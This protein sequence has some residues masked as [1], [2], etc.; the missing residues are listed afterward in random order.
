M[1]G[2]S[3]DD[4]GGWTAFTYVQT[5]GDRV[6]YGQMNVDPTQGNGGT[7]ASFQRR[8]IRNVT[9][10]AAW[11]STTA[12]D[13]GAW[14]RWRVPY[15][16]LRLERNTLAD[17]DD[18]MGTMAMGEREVYY[19]STVETKT[20]VA[21]FVTNAGV[22][23]HDTLFRGSGEH[24]LDGYEASH[25]EY[26]VAGHP[27][28][29]RTRAA[30][31]EPDSNQLRRLERIELWTKGADGKLGELVQTTHFEYDYSLCP[32]LPNSSF[33][34]QNPRVGKLTLKRVYFEYNGVRESAIRPYVFGYQY[35]TVDAGDYNALSGD[36]LAKY[37]S[38][39]R[40]V[41]AVDAAAQNPAYA[42]HMIDR[43]GNY[44][45]DGPARWAD[46]NP[47]VDQT[48]SPGFDPAA[49]QLKWIRLPSG[50]EIQVQYEQND[51]AFV[52]DHVAMAMVPLCAAD[53]V[54]NR[55]YLNLDQL[56][57]ANPPQT[58]LAA[59][60][61]AMRALYVGGGEKAYFKFLT[62][63]TG[64]AAQFSAIDGGTMEY[65]TGY[66]A[67][68]DVRIAPGNDPFCPGKVY[69]QFAAGE[70]TTPL[71]VAANF[72]QTQRNGIAGRTGLRQEDDP[73]AAVRGLMAHTGDQLFNPADFANGNAAV[74]N[75]TVV[76][77]AHSW[78][79]IPLG[80]VE[81]PVLGK[82][83]GGADVNHLVAR[84]K[85]V[86]AKKGGGVRVKRLLTFDPGLQDRTG[87]VYGTEYLYQT[88]EGYTSGVAAN[89]PAAGGE[90]SALVRLLDKRTDQSW[91]ERIIAGEDKEQFEGPIGGSLLPGAAVTYGRVVEK[92]I[93]DGKTNAGFS[94]HE[95]HTTRDYPSQCIYGPDD[96]TEQ[97]A[98]T[99]D[100]ETDFLTIPTPYFVYNKAN[101]WATQGYRFVLN[102]MNGQP[103]SMATYGG[104][105]GDPATWVESSA[106]AYDYFAPGEQVP[107]LY[108]Y[109]ATPSYRYEDPGKE[110]EVTMEGRAVE[111]VTMNASMRLAGGMVLCTPLPVPFAGFSGTVQYSASNLYRH[112]TC[113][114]VRYPAIVRSVTARKD[115]IGSVTENVGFNP[116][117]GQPCAQRTTDG[118]SG[119]KLQY[120]NG[121][122]AA[123]PAEH[124]R[125]Y[126]AF[127]YPAAL[128]YGGMARKSDNERA[129]IRTVPGTM[130]IDKMYDNGR[131]YL[132]MRFPG[133][134]AACSAA[135]VL[136]VGDLVNVYVSA[137][138]GY[139]GAG[140]LGMYH[141]AGISGNRV[142]LQPH[143]GILPTAYAAG[144]SVRI[145]RSGRTNQ[146]NAARAGITV[147]TPD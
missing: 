46:M 3:N 116:L 25:F 28:Y 11:A 40:D 32:E 103:K 144:V 60:A 112:V 142:M 73:D 120:A 9:D 146:L 34:G 69:V 85:M 111:D 26:D 5:A 99:I 143:S 129:D 132:S 127:S 75:G 17:P 72:A 39:L 80:Q 114:V 118:Y 49:W 126:K 10:G 141:V 83:V 19:M 20:H 79:R 14:Y 107:M 110:M 15:T 76:E 78:F 90:E 145:V 140:T 35:R 24:R 29:D 37:E 98:T 12:P 6:A 134:G 33:T 51:Y 61:E 91:L 7:V 16:G 43:W 106:M 44:Q 95:F 105:Y 101:I 65:I 121:V 4:Y 23:T 104:D 139:S 74:A 42:D 82:K 97:T 88:E 63:L 21:V 89:E 53:P 8:N 31:Q 130:V 92:N 96:V 38:R 86:T 136:T 77:A 147:Y 52:Q 47:W 36:M 62:S 87:H 55:Y 48:P 13:A 109:T 93:H 59:L 64:N 135:E 70:Y 50:G 68:T 71:A 137:G 81:R 119:L 128:E 41:D 131:H 66:G 22:Y 115:G 133:V 67:V 27:T 18:D 102:D 122:N 2:P 94:I 108:D 57:G 30:G 138:G 58:K 125:S 84:T 45:A 56:L 54:N 100:P 117:T 123:P 113:K 124:N 1:N